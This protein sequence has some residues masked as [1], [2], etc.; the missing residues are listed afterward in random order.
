MAN[1]L[2]VDDDPTARDLVTTVLGYGGHHCREA[3]DG[4]DALIEAQTRPPDLIIVDLLMPTMDG[5]EFVR[6][7]REHAALARTPVV[8]YTATYLESE[9]RNLA[10]ACGV[11]QII[12][13][14]A[15]PQDILDAVSR[16][17]GTLPAPIAPPPLEDFRQKHLG[18]LLTKLSQKAESV[19]PR[20]DAMI[21]L[22]L[23]LASERDPQQLLGSFCAAVRKVIGAKYATVGLLNQEDHSL[24]F[25]YASG[26]SPETVARLGSAQSRT[27]YPIE[28]LSERQSRRLRGLPGNP[29]SV[30]LPAEHPPVHSFLSAPILSPDRVYGW[31]CLADKLGAAEFNDEDE[32]LAQVLAAQV[33]RIY[34]N[35]SL[36][37]EVNR[38]VAQLEA[39]VAERKRAQEAIRQLNADLEKRVAERTAALQSANQELEAF[40]YSVSHDLR[41]PLRA[42]EGYCQILLQDYSPSLPEPVQDHLR[43]IGKSGNR[44]GELIDSLLNLSQIG[45]HELRHS[46]VNLTEIGQRILDELKQSNSTRQIECR[47]ASDLVVDGDP[48]LLRIALDNLLRNAWKF[49]QNRPVT[50]IELGA[51]K[52]ETE[53]VFFVRDNGA[54]FDMSYADKLF[55]AFQRLHRTDE[56]EGTGIGLAI[57]QRIITRHGGRVWAEAKVGQGATFYFSLSGVREKQPGEDFSKKRERP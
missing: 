38:S 3:V 15:E 48:N 25:L 18:L 54:G 1:I 47:V 34:E 51:A 32:G 57:V 19:V 28:V 27:A 53:T 2:V 20:L 45:R 43:R 11:T 13:K 31:L 41:G 44:M 22:G 16:N 14:P 29:Q 24:R 5:F 6:R 7:L 50:R 35:G 42:I 9:A 8:F 12:T 56:F 55:G 23:Q 26:M 21:D 46:S 40:S 52:Q 49:T 37:A 17:L 36:F 4:A 39:E 10:R 33:G 30:G